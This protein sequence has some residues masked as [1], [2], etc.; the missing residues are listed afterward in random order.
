M[1]AK[2]H[3]LKPIETEGCHEGSLFLGFWR[4]GNLPISL[5]KIQSGDI[6]CKANLINNFIYPCHEVG[7][8]LSDL[9]E[10]P[11]VNTEPH[12]PILLSCNDNR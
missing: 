8:K 5:S 1:Q 3:N 9:V 2:R 6:L 4:Q 12:S 10:L 11:V 7:I